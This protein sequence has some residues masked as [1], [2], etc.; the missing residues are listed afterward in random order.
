MAA[1]DRVRPVLLVGPLSG[2]PLVGGIET[3][4]DMI[5]RSALV[6]RHGIVFFNSYRAPSREGTILTRLI[7]Q[8]VM[9][10]RFVATLARVRPRLVHIKT[11]DRVN[12]VQNSVY[13]LVARLSARPVVLQIHG[14]EFDAW[15]ESLS[16]W[17]RWLVRRA[18]ALPTAIIALSEYWRAFVTRLHVTRPVHVI[19]NGVEL[20]LARAPCRESDGPLRVVTFGAIGVRKGH[21]DIVEA[22]ALL[23]EERA[24]FEFAGTDEYG[25]ETAQLVARAREIGVEERIRF[26]G[27]VNG[28]AK[29][30]LLAHSDVFLLPARNENMP[31]SV[32]EAMAA[33]LP[34]VCTD[35]GA[36]REM[37]GGSALFVPIGDPAAIATALRTLIHDTAQRR[38]LGCDARRR[39]EVAYSFKTVATLLDDLYLS[40][41]IT[42]PA[43]R[44]AASAAGVSPSPTTRLRQC[45]TRDPAA[46]SRRR[47]RY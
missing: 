45:P 1:P 40:P 9:V 10:A 28:P 16:S 44:R 21:F 25:G 34:I 3:G 6:Q 35:V 5:L 12:F 15:Y 20:D 13:V 42:A 46:E 11:A 2:G 14:G 18:L 31:N 30:D 8:L 32:L 23:H 24:V 37:V 7:S 36:V 47:S 19:P 33:S 43:R 4:I 17:R 39:S 27:A 38:R 26:L 29:W 41:E 22:A